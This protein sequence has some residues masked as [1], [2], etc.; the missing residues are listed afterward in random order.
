MEGT[1]KAYYYESANN[2]M[3]KDVPIPRISDEEVLVKIKAVGICHTDLS[4][5]AG[6]NI[7]PVP[8]PFIGGHEWSGEIVEAG[9][10]VVAFK[11]GDRVV[12]ECNS[13]CGS[14]LACQEGHEDYCMVAP[15]QRGINTDGAFCEYY[16]IIPRLLHKI[17]DTMDWVTASL[18]EPFTVAYTGIRGIGSC[19]A[20]DTVV[21]QGGGAIGLGAVAAA[22]GMGARV[23]LS[24]SHESR[25]NMATRLGAYKTIDRRAEDV[26]KIV[27][28]LT[29][30][31]GA[32]L[33][34]EA[35]GNAAS[36]KQ[37]LD[38]VRNNGRIAYLGMDPGTEIPIEIGKIM[39]K[40]IRAQGSL[41]SPGIWDRAIKFIDWSG[42]D[43]KMLSS[44]QFPFI[45]AA[46][47][48]EYTRD[49]DNE[50]VK[51]TLLME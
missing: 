43:L 11:V 37:S 24:D 20:G 7:V 41:G 47:A 39:M 45:Q 29:G 26:V 33:V 48:F 9:K 22:A 51:V 27:N 12:G 21:V 25:R 31:F 28:D 2:A 1:M 23:I 30:G 42:I 3:I 13:G 4:V 40:G 50:F 32:D 10:G 8:F 34:I 14:C 15:V 18:M 36:M 38:L 49:R 44:K 17:P 35:A 5:L 16:R 46:E 19:D 6:I